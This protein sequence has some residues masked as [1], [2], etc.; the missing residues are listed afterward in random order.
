MQARSDLT[1]TAGEVVAGTLDEPE[2]GVTQAT[3]QDEMVDISESLQDTID[4]I[5]Q[6]VR[7]VDPDG[8]ALATK[9]AAS[10]MTMLS[11]SARGIAQTTDD[12]DTKLNV[13]AS[14]QV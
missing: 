1:V 11:G 4:Q 6:V 7:S 13:V 8:L 12:N 10:H 9:D 14:A 2:F 5:K 3:A